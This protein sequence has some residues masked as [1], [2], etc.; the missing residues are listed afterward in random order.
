MGFRFFVLTSFFGLLYISLGL[1]LYQLQVEK[2]D[3]YFKKTEARLSA[4]ENLELRRGQIFFTDRNATNIPVSMNRDYPIIYAVP[5][6]ITDVENTSRLLSSILGKSTE[7][8][9]QEL[10]NPKSLFKLLVE[11]ATPQQIASVKESNI[12]GVYFDKKQYRFYP[13]NNLAAQLLG[14]VGVNEKFDEPIGLYG[15]EKF[16]NENLA[17]GLDLKFTIDRNIQVASEEILSKLIKKFSSTGGV[18]IV[19]DPENGKILSLANY[20]DFDPN[21]Y[22]N[23]PVKN[24]LNQTTQYVYEPG[25]VFKPL[26]M[27]AG[28]DIGVITTSTTFTDTGSVTLNTKT[29]KNWDEKAHGKLTMT[30]VIEQSVNTGAVFAEQKIGHKKFYEYLRKFGFGEKTGIDLP[31]EVSG[32]LKNLEKKYTRDIDFATASFGQ[33]TAVTPIQMIGAFAS[34]ANGGLL[35]RPFVS[36]D[37]KPYIVRRVMQKS[38]SDAVIGMME[39]AVEKARLASIPQYR[40]AGKTG[41]AQIPDFQ[42]GGYEDAFIH[43]Y[44]GFAPAE[45][46]KFVILI[47]LDR[48]NAPLAGATVVPAFKELAQFILNYY[49]IPPENLGLRN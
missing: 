20:P 49:N 31:D 24:F 30:N 32:S 33:G 11:K 29:I 46:A 2:G 39:S 10:N 17:S 18:I 5:K 25:S 14:F 23:W 13:F 21:E 1:K 38:T 35:M 47:K 9:T 27:S 22:G 37:E 42:N 6:E 16:H 40:V 41:T 3:Y 26:T 4:L 43:T 34:I 28:I 45:N 7:S 15:L 48:P 8:L 12:K 36:A 19:E 44:I